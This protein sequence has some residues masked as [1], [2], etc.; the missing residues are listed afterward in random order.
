MPRQ[1]SARRQQ[2]RWKS[3]AALESPTGQI[4]QATPAIGVI[5]GPDGM[6]IAANGGQLVAFDVDVPVTQGDI[7]WVRTQGVKYVAGDSIPLNM[8]ISGYTTNSAPNAYDAWGDGFNNT[9][10]DCTAGGTVT[11]VAGTSGNATFG[12]CAVGITPTNPYSRACAGITLPGNSTERGQ[13]DAD[14]WRGGWAGRECL[15]K[16]RPYLP[17]SC[18]GESSTVATYTQYA[19][20]SRLISDLCYVGFINEGFNDLINGGSS[21]S[22]TVIANKLI[23]AQ[24]MRAMGIIACDA[25][26]WPG[27]TTTDYWSSIAN[28]TVNSWEA[29]RLAINAD[30]RN[31]GTPGVYNGPLLDLES[32]LKATNGSGIVAAPVT[33]NNIVYATGAILQTTPNIGNVGNGVITQISF[34]SAPAGTA[35]SLTL[36]GGGL[37][38]GNGADPQSPLYGNFSSGFVIVMTS[39]ATNGAVFLTNGNNSSLWNVFNQGNVTCTS[40]GIAIGDTFNL[41]YELNQNPHLPTRQQI[42]LAALFPMHTALGW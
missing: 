39:G 23:M 42:A 4:I 16:Q 30:A 15:A 11:A 1:I 31:P 5:A 3:V 24:W 27:T 21:V 19:I 40:S 17:V 20:R 33:P 36:F 41:V 26:M 2:A 12:P 37:I 8:N 13:S 9:T 22:T 32:Y 10:T 29:G 25:T 35:G 34:Q 28:Q 7:W 38:A 6:T 14:S 18:P